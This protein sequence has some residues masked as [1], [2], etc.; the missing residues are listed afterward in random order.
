MGKGLLYSGML[1][2]SCVEVLRPEHQA[3]EHEVLEADHGKSQL[4]GGH[5]V[6]LDEPAQGNGEPVFSELFVSINGY[7]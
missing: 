3:L 5:A 6:V 7:V 4:L 2:R 1:Q